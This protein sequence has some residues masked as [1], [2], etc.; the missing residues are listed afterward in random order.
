M[1]HK[2]VK[3]VAQ[4]IKKSLLSLLKN[5]GGSGTCD[6]PSENAFFSEGTYGAYGVFIKSYKVTILKILS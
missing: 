2:S 4:R 5:K 1:T 6:G 3:I